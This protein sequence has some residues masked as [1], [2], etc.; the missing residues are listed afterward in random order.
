MVGSVS[1]A[2]RIYGN[3]IIGLYLQGFHPCT[4]HILFFPEGLQTLWEKQFNGS[5]EVTSLAESRDRVSG[6]YIYDYIP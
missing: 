6:V 3:D 1:G 4:P 2:C 5:R